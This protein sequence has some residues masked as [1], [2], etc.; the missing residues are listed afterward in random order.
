MAE[1]AVPIVFAATSPAR[2]A[3]ADRTDL[4]AAGVCCQ[5]P[6]ALLEGHH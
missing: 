3:P 5:L 6:V 4:M 2:A 1:R